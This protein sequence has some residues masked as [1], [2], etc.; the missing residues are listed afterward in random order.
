MYVPSYIS[1]STTLIWSVLLHFDNG[2]LCICK[3]MKATFAV[4]NTHFKNEYSV[5]KILVTRSQVYAQSS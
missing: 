4:N 1:K 2:D 3:M 5:N